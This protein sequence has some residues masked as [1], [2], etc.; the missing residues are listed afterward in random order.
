MVNIAAHSS[1]CSWRATLASVVLALLSLAQIAQAQQPAAFQPQ[2]PEALTPPKPT[3]VQVQPLS[4]APNSIPSDPL[5][6]L[7]PKLLRPLG[8]VNSFIDSLSSNDAAFEVIVGESR[9]L[10]LKENLAIAGKSKPLIA[11]GE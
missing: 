11:L 1:R 3:A 10:T 7:A 9:L 5:P 2:P 8:E 6:T 4:P